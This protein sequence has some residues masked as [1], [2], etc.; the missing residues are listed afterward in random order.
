M[1]KVLAWMLTLMMLFAFPAGAEEAQ[2]PLLAVEEKLLELAGNAVRYPQV[3]GMADETLQATINQQLIEA[4]GVENYLS[5]VAL[6]MSSP[7]KMDVRYEVQAHG[8]VLSVIMEA[9]GAVVNNRATHVWTTA[10]VDLTTG[11]AIAL[12]A[13]FTDSEAAC[14]AVEEYLDYTVSPELSAHLSAGALT[15]LPEHFALSPTGVT[16]YYP[17]DQ[18]ATLSDRA[19]AVTVHFSE[20][21]DGLDLSEGSVLD[22]L[23]AQEHLSLSAQSRAALEE[24]LAQGKLGDIPMTIGESVQALTD[25]HG[26]LIDPD[27]YEGG[28]MFQLEGAA[29]RKA[30]LLTDALTEEWDTSVVQGI[31]AD[32]LNWHGLCTGRTV[33]EEWL[34]ALGEPETTLTVDESSAEKWR[35]VPG[36]SDYYT[37]GTYRLRLHADENGLL[38][39]VF[40]M[41]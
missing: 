22:R 8:D 38:S 24:S 32:R 19:G 30:F 29:Y 25:A 18:L 23:G 21:A 12:D 26:L 33:R 5:R 37:F 39:S 3:T 40:L 41:Q 16:F 20:M 9:T 4:L 13:L 2:E 27:L 34:A 31:R 36:R 35:I 17:I 28:R 10:N 7:V 11:E 6:L 14:M 15:P 1:K